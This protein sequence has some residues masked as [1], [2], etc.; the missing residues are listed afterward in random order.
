[1]LR[2]GK[3]SDR[4]ALATSVVCGFE[5]QAEDTSQL[6]MGDPKNQE[7][8][9]TS[10]MSSSAMPAG[11]CSFAEKDGMAENVDGEMND[12]DAIGDGAELSQPR[13][14]HRRSDE[15]GGIAER[16]EQEHREENSGETITVCLHGKCEVI[17]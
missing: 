16:D 8:L 3:W 5:F 7:S 10:R 6:R 14:A 11:N 9:A 12:I 13:C 2:I 15:A 1:M 17:W 4:E